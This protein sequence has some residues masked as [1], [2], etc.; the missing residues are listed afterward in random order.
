[1]LLSKNRIREENFLNII[2]EHE[3]AE[4]QRKVLSSNTKQYETR[5]GFERLLKLGEYL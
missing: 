3:I 5:I 1:M 2:V 4:E